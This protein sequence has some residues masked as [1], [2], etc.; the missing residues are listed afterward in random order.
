V[1]TRTPD[2]AARRAA[3]PY[4]DCVGIVLFN[5]DGLVFL[6][7]RMPEKGSSDTSEVAAPWQLPQGGIDKGEDALAAA[8]R[9]LREETN[10]HSVE[11]LAEA[12]DWIHYELPDSILGVVLGGK[13]R[14]QRQRW[15]AFL[16]TGT[17]DEIDVLT[18]GGHK[19]EF[20]AWRWDTLEAARDAVV[21]FKRAAYTEVVAAFAH[22]PRQLA[23]R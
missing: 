15:F 12:P 17:D 16:F 9:E 20:D 10:V 5:R 1:S 23:G 21:D 18:P 13:Y 4:R 14:G 3:M 19:P 22:I 6:G 8:R 7:K 2:M 11:L